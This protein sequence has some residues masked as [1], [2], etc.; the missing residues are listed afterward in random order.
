MPNYIVWYK[1]S[2]KAD[3][4]KSCITKESKVKAKFY[5]VVEE[6]EEEIKQ[7]VDAIGFKYETI[8]NANEYG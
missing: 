8:S 6:K 3:N 2:I 5:S 4:I 7:G 1:K